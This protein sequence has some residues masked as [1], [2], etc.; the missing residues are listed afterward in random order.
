MLAT[1][2]QS[3]TRIPRPKRTTDA[4][5]SGEAAKTISAIDGALRAVQ[6]A[7]M[8]SKLTSGDCSPNVNEDV[9]SLCGTECTE[10]TACS[11]SLSEDGGPCSRRMS[12]SLRPGLEDARRTLKESVGAEERSAR[13][14]HGL[15]AKL[16]ELR[17]AVAEEGTK[18]IC[19]VKK[20]R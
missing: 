6:T 12:F 9:E 20:T 8:K 3:T 11:S 19:K 4:R 7:L 5:P 10:S 2:S 16:D 17:E 1:A 13:F 15:F 18:A 14:T